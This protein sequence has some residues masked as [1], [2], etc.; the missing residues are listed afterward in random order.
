MSTHRMS[1]HKWKHIGTTVISEH[2]GHRVVNTVIDLIVLLT[3]ALLPDV[4]GRCSAA[5]ILLRPG[6]FGPRRYVNNTC[7]LAAH[8][9]QNL[10]FHQIEWK[11]SSK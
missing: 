7:L 2:V 9:V 4:K 10:M 1:T 3:G 6:S 5:H 8:T 11:L